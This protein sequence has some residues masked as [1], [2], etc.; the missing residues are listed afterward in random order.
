MTCETCKH[1]KPI[2]APDPLSHVPAKG[3]WRHF[4]S[5]EDIFEQEWHALKSK[6]TKDSVICQRYP[7]SVDK[8]KHDKCGEWQS[9]YP[10]TTRTSEDQ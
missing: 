8:L 2:D 9:R 4:E 3:F 6:R 5:T 7:R 1:S 10:P